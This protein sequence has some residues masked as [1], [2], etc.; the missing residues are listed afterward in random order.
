M[1]LKTTLIIST[2]FLSIILIVANVVVS[3]NYTTT[4]EKLKQLET[5]KQQL[6]EANRE[7]TQRILKNT[8]IY[9]LEEKASTLGYQKPSEIITVTDPSAAVALVEN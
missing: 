6:T 8:S 5:K 9:S 2:A 7:L 3:S 4:R 1:K